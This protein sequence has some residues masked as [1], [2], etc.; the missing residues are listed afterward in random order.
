MFAYCGNNPIL[1]ADPAGT[2]Y[3]HTAVSI[4][5]DSGLGEG[6]DYI[7][8]YL[9]PES[10]AN[11]DG[12]A[13]QNHTVPESNYVPVSSFDALV[14][15][16]NNL[17]AN[18]DDVYIYVHGDEYN[19]CFYD[20]LYYSANDITECISEIHI[21]GEIYL[22]SCKGGSHQLHSGRICV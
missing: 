2:S 3:H 16:L 20:A 14:N 9:H 1:Y 21:S 22:F 18:V 13:L 15:A 8:Y 10:D 19:L 11:L 7:I 12:P 6:D 5:T 17:P 4:R